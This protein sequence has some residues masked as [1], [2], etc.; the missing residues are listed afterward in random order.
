MNK[1]EQNL[2]IRAAMEVEESLIYVS[3]R[4]ADQ[5]TKQ[6]EDPEGFLEFGTI[7]GAAVQYFPLTL[8][9]PLFCKLL[10]GIKRKSN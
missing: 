9:L 8:Q 4:T 10:L 2:W 7:S 5:T 6:T 1:Q 3:R